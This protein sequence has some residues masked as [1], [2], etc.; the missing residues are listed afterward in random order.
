MA[1]TLAHT[2]QGHLLEVADAS[3]AL[4]FPAKR[5]K[6]LDPD[7]LVK[8]EFQPALTRAE[9]RQIRF[10]DLRHTYASLLIN[11]NENIKYISEQMGHA[12]VQITLDRYGHLFPNAKREAVLRLERSLF[13]P[14]KCEAASQRAE[15]RENA[16]DV[17]APSA[18]PVADEEPG[19]PGA[20]AGTQ[21]V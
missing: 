11:N 15:P 3:D 10:H 4:V 18:T 21:I 5:G 20:A 13:P 19:A 2:L 6:P 12:S 14:G 17:S 7:N 16:Q 8:R 1:P 9:L